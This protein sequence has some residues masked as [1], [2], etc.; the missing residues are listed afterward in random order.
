M[1]TT[2]NIG[3]KTYEANDPTDWLGEFNYNMNKIDEAVG[4][5]NDQIDVIEATANTASTT[6]NTASTTATNASTTATQAL[7]VANSKPSINDS[8]AGA[9]STY[10]SNKIEELISGAGGDFP[11]YQNVV[12]VANSTTLSGNEL[13][14]TYT[15]TEDCYVYAKISA[16]PLT[17]AYAYSSIIFK[18][19]SDTI[20]NNSSSEFIN[21][22]PIFK[23]KSN[24]NI[25][26]KM[27]SVDS[28]QTSHTVRIFKIPITN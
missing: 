1:Q 7:D 27:T 19:G 13:S 10:S 26:C 28:T 24:T 14:A 3:L 8:V 6:A 15:T 9:T 18:I 12:E 11:D 5:Q 21:Q 2:T 16:T 4:S 20:F 22:T 23:V 17:T 25:S